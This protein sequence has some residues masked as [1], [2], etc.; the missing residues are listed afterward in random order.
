MLR[1]RGEHLVEEVE[2]QQLHG[3][4]LPRRLSAGQSFAN[5]SS[6]V[7]HLADPQRAAFARGDRRPR[8]P[9]VALDSETK[10]VK[11]LV[12]QAR[13]A[14]SEE[15]ARE[16]PCVEIR[17]R[18]ATATAGDPRRRPVRRHLRQCGGCAQFGEDVRDQRRLLALALPVVPSLGLKESVLAAAGVGGGGVAGGGRL[19]AALGAS[20]AVK[21]AAIGV[22]AGGALAGVAA[23]SPKLVD[24][25]QAAVERSAPAA[26][27][28]AWHWPGRDRL[29]RRA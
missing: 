4:V 28:R 18:I 1:A 24:K 27:R 6:N 21:I 17:E 29:W 9:E 26:W 15:R 12:F 23:T 5:S 16:I 2:D 13:S 8:S 11:A 20:G 22:A 3:W 14:L 25:A 7:E 19:L 10:Q